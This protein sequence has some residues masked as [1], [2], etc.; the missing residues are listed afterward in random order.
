MVKSNPNFVIQLM[1]LKARPTG[2]VALFHDVDTG[3]TFPTDKV[4]LT[5]LVTGRNV[6]PCDGTIVPAKRRIIVN[7]IHPISNKRSEF[8]YAYYSSYPYPVDGYLC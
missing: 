4:K 6:T 5:L 1:T 8:P 7:T 2:S 3:Q